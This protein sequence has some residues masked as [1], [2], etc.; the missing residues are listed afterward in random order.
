ML[1]RLLLF[2][3]LLSPTLLG[4]QLPGIDFD[5]PPRREVRA[6]WLTTLS[7]LD[8][9]SR[10]A[11]SVEGGAV[12]RKELCDILD[13][14]QAAGINTVIFQTRVRATTVYPSAIEPWDGT[15]TGT[16]GRAPA[17]D[18]LAFA[19]E[20]CHR[21][22]MELHAWVVAFPI[23]K[24]RTVRQLGGKAL[25]TRRP[26]LCRHA[27]DQWMMDPG[28][29]GTATYLAELCREIVEKYP[30]D[31][32]HLDYI[33]Y[34]E[35][36]IPWDDRATYRKYGRGESL[37]AWRSEN[38]TRCVRAIHDAVKAV[39]PWIKLSCSPVGKYADLPRQSS[40]GWNARDAVHQDAA[41]WLREGW[42]DW[43]FPMMYF[44]GRHFYPFAA[45]WQERSA[46]RCV[47]PGLGIYFLSEKEK[48]WPLEVVSRQMQYV[49][50]L[51]MGGTAHFRSRFFTDNVKGLYDFAARDFYADEA[52]LPAMTWADSIA[53][54][55]PQLVTTRSEKD[56]TLTW[57][58][59]TDNTPGAPVTY[60]VYRRDDSRAP[61]RLIV[62]GLKEQTLRLRPALP[63]LLHSEYT[64][65]AVDPFGNESACSE[66][67]ETATPPSPF[68]R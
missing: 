62:R 34:P 40:Y 5:A 14:L 37:A 50:Q 11:A 55:P 65:T 61:L 52:I 44:D 22:G 16:P 45:D 66:P 38:V 13:R 67:E 68:P 29:P 33:R 43:L 7:G 53:P 63:A 64:V 41:L 59:A 10:P 9:P 15:L 26:E 60:N 4:A 8:W 12:Q 21:R 39:R 18:P 35:K 58:A 23:C 57:T 51:G 17:Y 19:T 47:I 49:R 46:G 28:V 56:L 25:P 42:M 3:A 30:V 2:F 20:E 54:T 6:V 32:I 24:V 1:R 27:G 36:G 31:G 48:D